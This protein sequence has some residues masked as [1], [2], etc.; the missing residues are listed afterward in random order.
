MFFL[1][2]RSTLC[3]LQLHACNIHIYTKAIADGWKKRITSRQYLKWSALRRLFFIYGT[4]LGKDCHFIRIR[5]S[6]PLSKGSF[7]FVTLA[8]DLTSF[9][10]NFRVRSINVFLAALSWKSTNSISKLL[11]SSQSNLDSLRSWDWIVWGNWMNCQVL[12][13][14]GNSED[15]SEYKCL[16]FCI[17]DE[18]F[19]VQLL[20]LLHQFTVILR[21]IALKY[22]FSSHHPS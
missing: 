18:H 11:R 22:L 2:L 8:N 7:P 17:T 13:T 12:S 5:F 3:C 10:C 16:S 9:S 6:A 1:N 4:E 14:S 15:L 19:W 20:S 21:L